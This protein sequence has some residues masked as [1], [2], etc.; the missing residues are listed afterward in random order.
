MHLDT[1]LWCVTKETL[2]RRYYPVCIDQILEL[3]FTEIF[4]F[5]MMFE[6]EDVFGVF[7]YVSIGNITCLR[8]DNSFLICY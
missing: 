7:S 4:A 1:V 8:I 6:P 3:K 2:M 5:A